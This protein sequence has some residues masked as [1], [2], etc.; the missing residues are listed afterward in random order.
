MINCM[1]NSSGLPHNLWR[2]AL[3][4]ANFILNRI[5]HKKSDKSPYEVWNGKQSSNKILK[6]WGYLAKV[7][8]SL[9]KRTKLGQKTI[10]CVFIGYA[11]HSVT[12]RF[13]VTKSEIPDVNANTVLE[14]IEV[15]FFENIFPFKK[16]RH[17]NSGSKRK[18]ETNSS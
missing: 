18:Y 6:V 1:L 11:S 16:E 5:P 7:Q 17:N 14:S 4:T 3:I 15:E 13:L 12:Y 10:D 8:V 2:E 9:P